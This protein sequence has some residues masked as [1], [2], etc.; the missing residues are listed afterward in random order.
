MI[1]KK[2]LSIVESIIKQAEG[3]YTLEFSSE[4]K[5]KFKPG[6]FL[7]LAL[8]NNYDGVG[9]WP[10]SRCFSIQTTP[11][12][13][14]IK[15]TYSVKGRFTKLMEIQLEEG[16]EIWLK[17]PYGDLFTAEHSKENNIFIS[18]GTGITPYLSLFNDSSFS[19]YSNPKLFTGYKTRQMSFYGKEL[20]KAKELNSSLEIVEFFEDINGRIDESSI[21]YD[22]ASCYFISGPPDMIIYYKCVLI[23]NSIPEENIITDYWE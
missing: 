17:L 12:E 10:E 6:Q 7:H 3:V 16:R 8:D 11:S 18:G 4:K 19:S 13:K 1:V 23:N 15:I 9:Q 20:A 22:P 14:N 2:Y 21:M 5:F